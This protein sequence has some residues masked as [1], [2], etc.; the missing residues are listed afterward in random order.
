MKAIIAFLFV[1]IS[2]QSFAQAE[3]YGTTEKGGDSDIGTIFK[4]NSTGTNLQTL[5][6]FKLTNVG[7]IPV[8]KLTLGSNGKLYG[9]TQFGGAHQSTVPY[10]QYSRK[11][12]TLYEYDAVND[13]FRVLVDFNNNLTGRWPTHGPAEL[14]PNLYY[15]MVGGGGTNNKGIVY[16]Y[17]TS[18]HTFTKIH[19]FTNTSNAPKIPTGKLIKATN[20]KIY[21]VTSYGGTNSKGTVI[22]IDPATNAVTKVADISTVGNEPRSA[23][24]QAPN[25]KLYGTTIYGGTGNYGVIYEFNPTNNAI[26]K[27]VE[28]NGT[29]QGYYPYGPL[30][31]VGTNDLYGIS[32]RYDYPSYVQTFFVFKYSISTNTLVIEDSIVG[33]NLDQEIELSSTG[34]L[35][36]TGYGTIAGAKS[37]VYEFNTSTGTLS[38]LYTSTDSLNG[39][40]PH[41]LTQA[42]NG[43]YYGINGGSGHGRD[44]TL[45]EYDPTANTIN[46]EF[47]FN[48]QENGAF[49]NTGMMM[50]SNGKLYGTCEEGGA[51][52][53]GLIYEID[54]SDDSYTIKL[55]L[56]ESLGMHPKSTLME[57]SN[58]DFYLTTPEGGTNGYGTLLK[59]DA[60]NWT[61]IKKIDFDNTIGKFPSDKVTEGPNGKLYGLTRQGGSNGDGTLYEYNPINS[62][63]SVKYDFTYA[64]SVGYAPRGGLLLADNG[65]F[66]GITGSGGQNY[67]AEGAFFEYNPTTNVVTSKKLMLNSTGQ[68]ALGNTPMQASNG[69]IYTLVKGGG[70]NYIGTLAEH[71][72]GTNALTAKVHFASGLTGSTPYGNLME[73]ANGKLY[74]MTYSG[75]TNNKGVLFEYNIATST[76]TAK[77]NFNSTNGAGPKF[78][79]LVEVCHTPI[80]ITH[81]TNVSSICE[82]DTVM[83]TANASNCSRL[84][85]QWYKGNSPI[86]GANNDTLIINGL[87]AA[88]AG[89]YKLRVDGGAPTVFTNPSNLLVAMKPNVTLTGLASS[90]CDN[91]LAANLIGTPSN[92]IFS[93][94]DV[95]GNK[96]TPTTP[97]THDIIYSFTTSLGCSNSDTVTTTV[98]A[99]PDASF[100]GL[101]SGYCINES[102]VNLTPTTA[103]GTFIGAPMTG[104]TFSPSSY[105][106]SPG[107]I[108]IVGKVVYE[109]TGTN[110]CTDRDTSFV[111]IYNVPTVELSGMKTAYCASDALDTIV[112]KPTTGGTLSTLTGLT[113]TYFDPTAAN[114][115][116]NK[117][118]YTYTNSNSCTNADSIV[119]DVFDNPYINLGTDIT[120]CL[121]HLLTLDAGTGTGYTYLWN[122][123]TSNQHLNLDGSVLGLGTHNF[124]VTVTDANNCVGNDDIVVTVDACAGISDIEDNFNIEL[125][126]NPSNGLIFVKSELDFE[127]EIFNSMGAQVSKLTKSKAMEV[128]EIDLSSE[129]SGIY[130]LRFITTE[131]MTHK[132]VI[133]Q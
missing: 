26:A 61:V 112:L 87:T 96:F 89:I 20:G 76:A 39:S 75:G 65:M 52:D 33:G 70:N 102:D 48:S 35:I 73:A 90:Y 45:Y 124:D 13:S 79:S 15:G 1:F 8:D 127:L 36:I 119:F 43:K 123:Q 117:V 27:K 37:A 82:G 126:P 54:P 19:D 67:Y 130:F 125:Y 100:T 74:G 29:T 94:T 10:Y 34:K 104:N 16:T 131:G 109:V 95:T 41:G 57:T 72:P 133:I 107:M 84:S 68:Y 59:I 101:A 91:E 32:Y 98:K 69:N 17:N 46:L 55:D 105:T 23:M 115:G 132:K 108:L 63:Y 118:V 11:C 4:T 83:I 93:G 31:L 99:A 62:T 120:I 22:K 47:A 116:S 77:T 129:A 128:Y 64:N 58:G 81:Q 49:P 60:S 21:G 25:G 113:G 97:G 86:Q 111:N 53:K 44:G 110:G 30:T 50:A 42:S 14:S 106:Y 40:Y 5:V 85:Y 51:Y 3:F 92:G 2:F 6:D 114:S 7:S 38:H 12:G 66:Y 71:V 122:D 78:G 88:E 9:V 18:T 80:S 103:G 56:N 24:V 121:S 28:F